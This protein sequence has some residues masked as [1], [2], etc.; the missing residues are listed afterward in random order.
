MVQVPCCSTAQS[1]PGP[2]SK[3][4]WAGITLLFKLPQR[5][6][7]L[8]S[9]SNHDGCQDLQHIPE[10]TPSPDF[11]SLYRHRYLSQDLTDGHQQIRLRTKLIS[12]CRAANIPVAEQT[13]SVGDKSG[14]REEAPLQLPAPLGRSTGG[15]SATQTIAAHP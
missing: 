5:N 11:H 14:L 2:M 6:Q 4:E 7:P 1:S 12:I 13:A 15:C 9:G 10:A 3:G 8:A